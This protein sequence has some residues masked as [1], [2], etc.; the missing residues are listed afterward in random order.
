MKNLF[1]PTLVS[2]QFKIYQESLERLVKLFENS[3]IILENYKIVPLSYVQ[4]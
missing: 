1:L 3:E 4:T 2:D